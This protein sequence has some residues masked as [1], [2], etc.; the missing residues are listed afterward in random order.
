MGP[1]GR[2]SALSQAAAE[3]AW[4]VPGAPDDGA[5]RYRN[6]L[7]TCCVA[8][9]WRDATTSGAPLAPILPTSVCGTAF[10]TWSPCL[11]GIAATCWRGSCPIRLSNTAVQYARHQLLYQL[12]SGGV[13][14][15]VGGSTGTRQPSDLQHRPGRSVHSCRVHE[16]TGAG[17]DPDQLGRARPRAGQRVRRAAVACSQ[18]GDG[19]IT[20]DKFCFVRARRLQ[21]SW[22]RTGPRVRE[23]TPAVKAGGS[24]HEPRMARSTR[25]GSTQRRPAPLGPR[26]PAPPAVGCREAGGQ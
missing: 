8:S 21:L 23:D 12:L 17:G 16:S 15:R 9:R 1:A 10:S 7:P 13:G 26:L 14:G 11:T 19:L 25:R 20:N 22:R 5:K 4:S 2:G 24:S 3:R 18:V 6:A